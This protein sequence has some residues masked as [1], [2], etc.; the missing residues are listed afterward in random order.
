MSPHNR[1]DVWSFL[2]KQKLS[3]LE[4]QEPVSAS[5]GPTLPEY[6]E[7]KSGTTDYEQV[8]RMDLGVELWGGLWS[9][10]VYCC[11][12]LW[13]LW[14]DVKCCE[15]CRWLELIPSC[16]NMVSDEMLTLLL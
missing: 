5:D 13:G 15:L 12:E 10:A 11:V 6:Q 7:M 9:P 14:S 4:G 16:V 8:I 1:G 2:V 3:S